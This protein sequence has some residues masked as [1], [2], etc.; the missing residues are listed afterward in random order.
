[1]PE[2][3]TKPYLIRAIHQWCSDAGFTPYVAVAVGPSVRVPP[4][5]VKNG[6]IVLNVSA[7]ATSRLR[8]G[9]DAIEFQARFSGVARD[10]YVPME[11]VIAIY[12]RE[13]GQGMAFEITRASPSD[14]KTGAS[15][16]AP[17]SAGSVT[18]IT[19]GAPAPA[20]A[21]VLRLAHDVAAGSDEE[22]TGEPDPDPNPPTTPPPDRPRLT[23]VK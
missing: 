10:V 7:L 9:N 15:D 2:L 23:R 1:M 20:P 13:N 11:S 14:S 16:D 18:T 12:A 8:L 4:E 19:A 3:S 21:P 22:S 6:E 17:E 5:H